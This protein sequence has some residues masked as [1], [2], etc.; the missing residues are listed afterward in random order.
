MRKL[1]IGLIAVL[2]LVSVSCSQACEPMPEPAP[3]LK[4]TPTPMPTPSSAPTP[5]IIF[6]SDWTE[7][8]TSLKPGE[9]YRVNVF[10]EI[11]DIIEYSWK[12][13]YNFYGVYFWYINP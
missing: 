2:L 6:P 13:D 1:V 9:I 7:I 12:A 10:A 11:N 4:S 3:I 8:Q 5:T